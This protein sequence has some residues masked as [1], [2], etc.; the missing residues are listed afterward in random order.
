[1]SIRTCTV[2]TEIITRHNFLSCRSS[3]K[4]RQYTNEIRPWTTTTRRPRETSS[5]SPPRSSP[6]FRRQLYSQLCVAVVAW[7]AQRTGA[8][9][10][11]LACTAFSVWGLIV[12]DC[13][14]RR[15]GLVLHSGLRSIQVQTSILNVLINFLGCV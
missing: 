3:R 7:S 11:Q 5:T 15:D 6:A 10:N 8:T 4:L 14:A 1:M 13:V 2:S 9:W 12:G